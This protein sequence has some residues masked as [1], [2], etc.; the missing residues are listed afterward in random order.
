MR[1]A[2]ASSHQVGRRNIVGGSADLSALRARWMG[3]SRRRRPASRKSISLALSFWFSFWIA[4]GESIVSRALAPLGTSEKSIGRLALA[5]AKSASKRADGQPFSR[6]SSL[7]FAGPRDSEIND[8][9]ARDM[10][11]SLASGSGSSCK[12]EPASETLAA[13]ALPPRKS[14]DQNKC[15]RSW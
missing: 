10:I 9:P 3:V 12:A 11:Y 1:A 4:Q 7:P 8:R 15:S 5:A 13:A 6:S 2:G 14:N